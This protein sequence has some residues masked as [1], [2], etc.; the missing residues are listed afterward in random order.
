[1]NIAVI[2]NLV[3]KP[4]DNIPLP[5]DWT[6]IIKRFR[7]SYVRHQAGVSHDLFICSSGAALSASTM[8]FLDELD[9]KTIEYKGNGWDIGAYQYCARHLLAYDLVM[10]LNSQAFVVQD[11]WLSYF[12]VA[13]KKNGQG[14]YGASSS[15]EVAPHIRTS[16]FAV[17]P[18]LLLH[19]PLQ[20]RSRY[21]ACVFEHSP[22]NFSLWALSQNLPVYVVMRSGAYKLFESRAGGDIFRRGSQS[23]LLVNDRHTIIYA[24]SFGEEKLLLERLADGEIKT[25]FIYLKGIK[26]L[27]TR[28]KLLQALMRMA[29]GLKRYL[30][31]VSTF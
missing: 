14:V 31:N 18:E 22:S 6:G 7:D 21:D 3:E 23:D 4:T 19:Y 1:M 10:L 29:S 30:L 9:Y 8:K 17:S 25:D 24:K 20:V 5:N 13:Y 16:C 26:Y 11:D 15:F 12:A 27:I 2:Y 28:F